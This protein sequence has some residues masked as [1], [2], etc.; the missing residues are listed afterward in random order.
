MCT[1]YWS[2]NTALWLFLSFTHFRP[3]CLVLTG[4]P[5]SRPALVDLVACFTK[6]LSLMMC[7]NVVIVSATWHVRKHFSHG[8]WLQFQ[9]DFSSWKYWLEKKKH[10][11]CVNLPLSLM[12]STS[13]LLG[14]AISIG[15]I[16]GEQQRS[17]CLVKQAES[18]VILQ[19]C[20][21]C[22]STIWSKHAAAGQ[23]DSWCPFF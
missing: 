8:W 4:A 13:C 23:S 5:S 7:A 6:H 18:E 17:C 15:S 21:G 19:R 20:G 3:Q 12:C 1:C 2:V 11:I 14:W 16:K 9:V 22:R 10:F